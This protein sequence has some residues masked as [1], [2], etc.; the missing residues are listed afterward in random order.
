V[1][2]AA[3]VLLLSPGPGWCAEPVD[4]VKR[5]QVLLDRLGDL[6]TAVDPEARAK[7]GWG[8]PEANLKELRESDAGL[9]EYLQA[10]PNDAPAV[11]LLMRIYDLR[12]TLDVFSFFTG[13]SNLMK[14]NEAYASIL[15]RA[16]GA[17]SLNAEL[18]YWRGR[19][20]AAYGDPAQ[21][22][23]AP[24]P[25][26][27]DAVREARRAVS[28]DPK[29]GRYKENLAGMLLANG[30]EAGARALYREVKADH[31]M[32]LLLHDWE[33]MP[34]IEGAETIRLGMP[35]TPMGMLTAMGAMA[36]ALVFRGTAAEFERRCRERWPGFHLAWSDTADSV[37]TRA[38]RQGHQLLRWKGDILVPDP[39]VK[40]RPALGTGGIWLEAAE[41][42]ARDSEAAQ[43]G[44]GIKP[45]D[46]ICTVFLINL[47]Q[48]R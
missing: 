25:H 5:A 24:N 29:E 46:T 31:P 9:K 6:A 38:P 23:I 15:D 35:G 3:A 32:Y 2:A 47:R 26:L 7:A 13:S 44:H 18:H 8:D 14:E 48:A 1:I 19:L 37:R 12:S 17:D 10:H 39:S 22:G 30:D 43:L 40:E 11:V 21:M 4:P 36:R 28:L 34:N 33:R 45:G 41:E 16:L 20:Y 27:P 42:R